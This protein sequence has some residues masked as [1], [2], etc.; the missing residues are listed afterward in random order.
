MKEPRPEVVEDLIRAA[1]TAWETPR[2]DGIEPTPAELNS[3]AIT[4][5]RRVFDSAIRQSPPEVVDLNRSRI[6]DVLVMLW[7]EFSP[8]NRA[9]H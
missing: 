3:A 4:L 7:S 5:T 1:V 6:E 2:V 8:K 9:I